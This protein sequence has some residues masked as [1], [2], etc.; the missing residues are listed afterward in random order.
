MLSSFTVR[1]S[2][3]ALHALFL[4]CAC[5]SV[6]HSWQEWLFVLPCSFFQLF[7]FYIFTHSV[8]LLLF[9]FLHEN[10]QILNISNNPHAT[11]RF[12]NVAVLMWTW[13]EVLHM[14]LHEFMHRAAVTWLAD[15]I[16]T[17]ISRC[18]LLAFPIKWQVIMCLYCHL[19]ELYGIC[20]F[21]FRYADYY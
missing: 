20:L 11:V 10:Q 4:F 13:A 12:T 7:L 19:V 8:R 2:I 3:H 1:R 17:L 18:S 16:V 15:W 5:F 9:F 21:Q 14:Y 6:H